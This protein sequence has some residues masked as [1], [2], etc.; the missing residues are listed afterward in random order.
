MDPSRP[1]PKND[2]GQKQLPVDGRWTKISR[3]LV[4][5]TALRQEKED[6]EE[7][8]DSVIVHRVVPKEDLEKLV[9]RSRK[10]CATDS[11]SLCNGLEKLEVRLT[12]RFEGSHVNGV[13]DAREQKWLR[14]DRLRDPKTADSQITKSE[15]TGWPS[16]VH[17][18]PQANKLGSEG[19]EIVKA[20]QRPAHEVFAHS[21]YER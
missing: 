6:F 16:Q 17:H 15:S 7:E 2:F 12:R 21:K 5:P 3:S 11:K 4:N 18:R 20:S 19:I 13:T 9:Q 14:S 1:K 10:A 8:D